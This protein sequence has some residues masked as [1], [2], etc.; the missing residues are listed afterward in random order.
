MLIS[1]PLVLGH[2]GAERFGLWI[3][4]TSLILILSFTDLG[5]GNGLINAIAEADGRDDRESARV[6][7][8]NAF[9]LLAGIA[10]VVI[11]VFVVV[12]PHISWAG[13]FNI[14]S[15]AAAREAPS[16]TYALFACLAVGIPL[17]IVQRVQLGYQEAFWSSAC[18]TAGSVCALGGIIAGVSLNAGLAWFVVA[19]AGGPLLA[20]SINALLLFGRQRRWLMPRLRDIR[21]ATCKY[22]LRIGVAFFVLQAAGAV[23]YQSDALIVSRV[24]GAGEVPQY[25]V[26]MRLFIVLQVGL[27]LMVGP[28]WPAYGESIARGD[29]AWAERALRRSLLFSLAV[30]VPACAILVVVARPLIRVWVGDSVQPSFLLLAGLAAWTVIASVSSS[31]AMFLN[32]ANLVGVQAGLAALMAVVNVILSVVLTGAIGV[33][34]VVWGSLIA[35]VTFVLIPLALVASRLLDRLRRGVLRPATFAEVS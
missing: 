24:L 30:S 23:A 16:A 4:I 22:L 33:S 2:L 7:V 19:A 20:S 35:Q 14:S 1:V 15:A 10:V 29:V 26:P 17:G 6:Y 11:V 9:F 25:A 3:T 8:S 34:G 18:S 32:G 27:A 21:L 5:L 13:L 28:L 12:A 31:L